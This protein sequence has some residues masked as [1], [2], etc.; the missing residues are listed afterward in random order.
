VCSTDNASHGERF[1]IDPFAL[2]GDA[3]S[4]Y[5]WYGTEPTLFDAPSRSERRPLAWQCFSFLATTPLSEVMALQP[6]RVVP[7]MGF[8]WG[9]DVLDDRSVTLRTVTALSTS[10]WQTVLGELRAEYPRP[11]WTFADGFEES[12]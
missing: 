3:R 12:A 8:G 5:C 10:D 6:R 4:P 9:F 2:F 11:S 1:E 7:V